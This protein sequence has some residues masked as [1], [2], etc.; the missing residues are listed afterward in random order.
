M[1]N[2]ITLIFC[3]MIG[4]SLLTAATATA[5]ASLGSGFTN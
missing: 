3:T 4:V 1:I 5:P 2:R